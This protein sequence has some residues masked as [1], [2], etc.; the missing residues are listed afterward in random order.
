LKG[1]PGAEDKEL[2]IGIKVGG[3][4]KAY[5][6]EGLRFAGK[7]Q[8]KLGNVDITLKLDKASDDLTVIDRSGEVVKHIIL[9][10]FVWKYIHPEA[11][12]Y[13]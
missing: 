12:V 3:T 8:D 10:W 11:E 4:S 5:K 9:Y 7:V 6:L 2:V 13:Q 1:D